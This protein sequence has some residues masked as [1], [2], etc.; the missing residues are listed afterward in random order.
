M[1]D[2]ISSRKRGVSNGQR[3]DNIANSVLRAEDRRRGDGGE[4]VVLVLIDRQR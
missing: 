3:V 1:N 4:E 2:V